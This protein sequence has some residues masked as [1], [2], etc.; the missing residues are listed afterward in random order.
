MADGAVRYP[1]SAEILYNLAC[2]ECLAGDS[3]GALRH[4]SESIA[5]DHSFRPLAKKDTDFDAVRAMPEFL[6]LVGGD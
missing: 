3:A 1:G 4:L 2:F 6:G 5:L